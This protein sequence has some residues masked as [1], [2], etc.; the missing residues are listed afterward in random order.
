MAKSVKKNATSTHRTHINAYL[1]TPATA[2]EMR[3]EFPAKS[4]PKDVS[5]WP[6]MT[7]RGI[8]FIR[9]LFAKIIVISVRYD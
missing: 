2:V 1:A 9:A 8:A 7:Q 6:A 4:A 3:T 5:S